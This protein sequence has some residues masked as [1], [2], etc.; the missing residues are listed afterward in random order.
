MEAASRPLSNARRKLSAGKATWPGR[1]Q[2]FR[3]NLDGAMRGDVL[4]IEGDQ[5]EGEAL[6]RP[7]MRQGRRIEAAESLNVLR[8]RCAADLVTLPAWLRGLTPVAT[9]PVTISQ[10]LQDLASTVD[11]NIASSRAIA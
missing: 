7:V 1:K 3:S 6:I 5:L 10:V 4:T 8:Q 2:V 9:Y 11:R